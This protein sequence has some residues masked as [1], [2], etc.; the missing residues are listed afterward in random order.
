MRSFLLVFIFLINMSLMSYNPKTVKTTLRSAA[1]EVITKSGFSLLSEQIQNEALKE[2]STQTEDECIDDSCLMDTGKMLSAQRLFLIRVN[3]LGKENYMFKITHINL[4]TNEQVSVRSE[5]YTGDLADTAKLFNFSKK[6]LLGISSD[7]KKSTENIENTEENKEAEGIPAMLEL[8]FEVKSDKEEE[9]NEKKHFLL[10][11]TKHDPVNV[12]EGK[13]LL[14]ISPLKMQIKEGFYTLIFQKEGFELTEKKFKLS[15]DREITHIAFKKFIILTI[16]SKLKTGIIYVNGADYGEIKNHNLELKLA[17]GE[18][19]ITFKKEGYED[20]TKKVI[21]KQSD[22]INFDKIYKNGGPY[23]ITINSKI[24]SSVFYKNK[25]MGETPLEIQLKKGKQKIKL[26]NELAGYNNFTINV[27][28]PDSFYYK[29]DKKFTYAELSLG[30]SYIYS[31][32]PF[33]QESSHL[34]FGFDIKL[35]KW[36]WKNFDIDILGGGF[37]TSFKKDKL[38]KFHILGFDY[39]LT[40]NIKLNMSLGPLFGDFL[41]LYNN[42]Q[43]TYITFAGIKAEYNKSFM[44]IFYIKADT[45]L[46]YGRKNSEKSFYSKEDDSTDGGLLFSA[47]LSAGIFY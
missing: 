42:E 1:E 34:L 24:K 12:Y 40:Q 8:L 10:I 3:D 9:N 47:N 32:F 4:E 19:N 26:Y 43:D 6:F 22:K 23:P 38:I 46:H 15:Q 36:S 41:N 33:Q 13:K 16:K 30:T 7:V 25:N 27:S 35:I 5:I 29:M 31:N 14:G 39:K 11:K 20:V 18:Y 17:E 37:Y 44:D 45:S 28:K 21:L 2:Q